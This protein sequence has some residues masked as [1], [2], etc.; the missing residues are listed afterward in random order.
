[1]NK[2]LEVNIMEI[3]ACQATYYSL[4]LSLINYKYTGWLYIIPQCTTFT[5]PVYIMFDQ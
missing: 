2:I 3:Q 5:S 4:K 1:M